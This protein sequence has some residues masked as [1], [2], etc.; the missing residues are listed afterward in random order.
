MDK[1]YTYWD[2]IKGKIWW[3][4]LLIIYF[5]FFHMPSSLQGIEDKYVVYGAYFGAFIGVAIIL[6]IFYIFYRI[7]LKEHKK[8]NKKK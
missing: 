7:K 8:P 2:Y 6:A 4:A 5:V 1:K 3:I